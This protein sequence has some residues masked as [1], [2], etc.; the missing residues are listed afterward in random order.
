[1]CNILTKG[2][3]LFLTAGL[4]FYACKYSNQ[5]AREVNQNALYVDHAWAGHP[6]GFDMVTEPPHQFVAYYDSNRIMTVAQRKL[7]EQNWTKI[8]LDQQ[9]GWDSHNSIEMAL[10]SQGH[11]HLSGNMHVDTL[12]YFKSEAPWQI[13]TLH[14]QKELIGSEE[15]AVT[16]PEFL[17]G[18]AGDLIFT[19]RDGSSGQGSQIFNRYDPET[20]EWSRLL[21]EPLLDGQGAMNAYMHGPVP[22]P[23]GNFHLIWVWRNNPDAATNHDLSYAQSPDLVNWYKSDGTPQQL[24]ITYQNAEVIDPVPVNGGM[25]NGNTVIGFDHRDRVVVTYHKFDEQGN[26]QVYNARLENDDWQIYQTTDWNFRWAFGGWG[27]IDSRV[28][29]H[30]VKTEGEALVQTIFVDTAGAEKY[31]LNKQ[32]L[33]VQKKAPAPKPYPA[34][35]EQSS[36]GYDDVHLIQNST[37][38]KRY[39][40]RWETLER[41]RDQ[42]RTG[43]LLPPSLLKLYTIS[44][45]DQE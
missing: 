7:A 10:D 35:L 15:D 36:P 9:V 14:R 22:G 28:G 4:I 38:G 41:N 6:V 16:Y 5:A 13:K 34:E 40:L 43:P 12:V 18:P 25:I 20:G 24:P 44:I 17:Q 19:Y 31:W 11:I 26:T 45:Q 32:D 42:A 37:G 1:M 3:L 33:S 27:S 23:D 2:W 29:V 30:S 8:K 39:L 21:D